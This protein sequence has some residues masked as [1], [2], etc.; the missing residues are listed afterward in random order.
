MEVEIGLTSCI[1]VYKDTIIV[2]YILSLITL[3][4][5]LQEL[6][7]PKIGPQSDENK[8]QDDKKATKTEKS[9]KKFENKYYLKF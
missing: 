3:G 4:F 1:V 8:L 7:L 9:R 2:V 5:E 6:G